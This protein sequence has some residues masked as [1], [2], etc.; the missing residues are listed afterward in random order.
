MFF[1]VHNLNLLK[2]HKKMIKNL[3]LLFGAIILTGTVN[4][5]VDVLSLGAG[6]SNSIYYSIS[7]G[8]TSSYEYADWDIAFGVSNQSLAIFYNEGVAGSLAEIE[9][10]VTDTTDFEASDTTDMVRIYNNEVSWDAGAFN[11][12]SSPSDPFDFGWGKYSVVT[13]QVNGTRVFVLKLRNGIYKKL[14][15][16]S[17]IGGVYTFRYADLDGENEVTQ[18]VTKSEFV[19]KTLAYYS[20]ETEA[21]VD[22]EPENWDIL[23]TRYYTP[24]PLNDGTGAVLEYVVTGALT[25]AGLEVAQADGVNPVSANFQDYEDLF[26]DSL[27]VIGHDWKEFDL[28]TF[29]FTVPTDR[30]YFVKN[31]SGGVWKIQFIDFEGSS[32]GGFALEKSFEGTITSIA[33]QSENFQS[34]NLFP[35]PADNFLNIQFELK[36]AANN[37]LIQVTDNLGKVLWTEKVQL[38]QGINT[39]SIPLQ[40][41]QGPYYLS[42]RTDKGFI[43]KPFLVNR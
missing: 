5:Q 20:F 43:A 41:A 40:L 4:A 19:G 30:V 31:D 6:Y 42:I 10:Y 27:T 24:L 35:N 11:H 3:R 32:T 23:F 18:T 12:V 9:L 25:N 34:F 39:R 7:D 36:A 16:E 33:N 21:V 37:G 28:A 38:V 8:S 15:I 29:Q 13:H 1:E 17:L 14:K 26:T 22:L 2:I